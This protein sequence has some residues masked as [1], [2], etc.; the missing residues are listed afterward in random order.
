M[1]TGCCG[2]P[3]EN[4]SRPVR[5]EA[6]SVNIPECAGA[7]RRRQDPRQ[8]EQCKQGGPWLQT[9]RVC[10]AA[11]S[12]SSWFSGIKWKARDGSVCLRYPFVHKFV[13]KVFSLSFT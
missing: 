6:G 10:R 9:T 2:N 11:A 1:N 13:A 4:P 5:V 3:E 7:E 12:S 8:K